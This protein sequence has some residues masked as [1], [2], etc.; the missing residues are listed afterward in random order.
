[1]S[2]KTPNKNNGNASNY[3]SLIKNLENI[4][5]E[6]MTLREYVG[7]NEDELLEKISGI[8]EMINRTEASSAE[9]HKKADSI[10]QELQKL[11]ILQV[12]HQSLHQMKLLVC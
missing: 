9:F 2:E 5:S 12:R 8:S 7:D 6:F 1:M 11:E 3:S 4:K 10:I